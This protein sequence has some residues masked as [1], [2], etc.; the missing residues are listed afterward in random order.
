MRRFIFG[1]NYHSP[2]KLLKMN[3]YAVARGRN[4]G[5]YMSWNECHAQVNKFPGAAYKKFNS[6]A[7]AQEFILDRGGS[8]GTE[9]KT[10]RMKITGRFQPYST[11]K[12]AKMRNSPRDD[13]PDTRDFYDFKEGRD[14]EEAHKDPGA[15]MK[16]SQ[17]CVDIFTDGACSRNGYNGAKAGFGVWFG[18][19]HPLNVAKPVEGRPTNNNAEIQ[20]VT[21]SA[22]L[23]KK[24]GIK[25]IRINTDSEFLIKCMTQWMPTWKARGWKTASNEPVVN[26]DELIKM[27]KALKGL[28]YEFNHVRGHSGIQ[29]N[30]EADKLARLGAQ[31]Y[32]H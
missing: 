20:A 2:I 17:G 6:K 11:T 10:K 23:S 5:I 31:M 18:H 13:S 30:E 8:S 7:E 14:L 4:P 24:H 26:K 19:N 16:D 15:F 12:G 1:L 22:L 9:G 32:K 27:E 3:Y 21:E 28:N 29:G 25:K